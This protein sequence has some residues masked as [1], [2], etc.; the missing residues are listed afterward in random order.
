MAE[1]D[2][3]SRHGTVVRG[4]GNGTVQEIHHHATDHSSLT[5]SVLI[6]SWKRPERLECCL[7]SLAAQTLLPDQ[8]IVVWQADDTATRD[9]LE[10]LRGILPFK[11]DVLHNPERGVVAAENF[12]LAHA[13]GTA[14]AL[15]DDD[16]EAPPHW[17]SRHLARLANPA[18]GAVGG[19]AVNHWQDG[20]P[21][22]VHRSATIGRF[23]LTG[24]PIGNMYDHPAEWAARE[25]II[26][27]HLVG[28]NLVIRRAAFD[29]FE[30]ELRPYWQFFELDACLQ[31]QARG[32]LVLFDFSNIVLH[33]P[34]NTAYSAGRDGDLSIKVY[35]GAYN[36]AFIQAKHT[37]WPLMPIRLSWQ[38]LIGRVNMPGP[39]AA[40]IAI[41]R[42]GRPFREIRILARTWRAVAAGWRDG[43]QHRTPPCGSAI[44]G[45]YGCGRHPQPE[46]TQMEGGV[47]S[48]DRRSLRIRRSGPRK[49]LW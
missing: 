28:Y 29:Q 11:L 35:N 43:L 38:L 17:L 31:V 40:A 23:S 47:R 14:I 3:A 1:F 20:T 22:P 13:I 15:I 4:C 18:I 49:R 9:R 39:M 10:K 2:T 45:G 26:V 34:S 36:L 25:P 12:A 42:F 48:G 46:D 5:A 21:L 41:R 8:V 27:D 6:P 37:P 32:Y 16:A 33:Y 44:H 30:T 19:P 7:R 24:Q